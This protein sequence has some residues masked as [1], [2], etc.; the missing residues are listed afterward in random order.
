MKGYHLSSTQPASAS[1]G[2]YLPEIP[3]AK[4]A[5]EKRSLEQRR[6]DGETVRPLLAKLTPERREALKLEILNDRRY[7][8]MRPVF[9][10]SDPLNGT[11]P[12][13]IRLALLM[14]RV[15]CRTGPRMRRTMA[16]PPLL[17]GSC[18]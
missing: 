6:E 14:W 17:V 18:T 11:L 9:E 8:D 5:R 2:P 12:D 4:E 10:Q 3:G 15:E 7:A 13:A 16:S 1:H